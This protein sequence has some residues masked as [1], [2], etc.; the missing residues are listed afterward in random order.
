M[1]A[2]IMCFFGFFGDRRHDAHLE[3]FDV[4]A[5]AVGKNL[6]DSFPLRVTPTPAPTATARKKAKSIA[7]A[8]YHFFLMFITKF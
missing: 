7:P 2:S 3:G 5:A 6:F 4:G 1:N 8:R